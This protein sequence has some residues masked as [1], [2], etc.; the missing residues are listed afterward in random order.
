MSESKRI[1]EEMKDFVGA[2]KWVGEITTYNRH[3]GCA[4]C[5]IFIPDGQYVI[6]IFGKIYCSLECVRLAIAKAEPK[7][8]ER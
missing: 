4:W 3:F 2:Q 8:Q 6:K 1:P 5:R 7:Q